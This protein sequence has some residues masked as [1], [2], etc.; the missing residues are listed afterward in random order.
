MK[1]NLSLIFVLLFLTTGIFAQNFTR[2]IKLTSPRMHGNDVVQVQKMLLAMGFDIVGEADGYFGPNSKE[3]LSQYQAFIGISNEGVFNKATFD[4]MY[5]TT[6]TR[7]QYRLGIKEVNTRRKLNITK[8][9]E[10]AVNEDWID[11]D[12]TEG[13]I[14]YKNYCGNQL[15]NIQIVT[16]FSSGKNIITLY[17]LAYNDYIMIQEYDFYGEYIG[18]VEKSA[19]ENVY[20]C[21][22]NNFYKMK[23]GRFDQDKS[24]LSNPLV[25]F[26]VK[27]SRK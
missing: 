5:G 2:E 11:Y 8:S 18:V 14:V 9:L 19:I 16:F 24:L 4:V 12:H 1:R 23:E 3:G 15:V 26:I 25:D 10:V 17:P 22:D 21:C 13:Q 20:F 6:Y 7:M 27:E